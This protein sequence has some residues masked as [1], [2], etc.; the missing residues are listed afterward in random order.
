M[1]TSLSSAVLNAIWNQEDLDNRESIIC[2]GEF[3]NE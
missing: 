3:L 2:E 1:S